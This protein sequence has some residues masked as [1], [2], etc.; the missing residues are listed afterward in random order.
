MQYVAGGIVCPL[1][2][3]GASNGQEEASRKPKT[4]R[5]RLVSTTNCHFEQIAA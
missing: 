2:A 1:R 5:F 4:D 3:N